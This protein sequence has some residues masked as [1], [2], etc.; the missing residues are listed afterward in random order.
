MIALRGVHAG[1]GRLPVLRGIS[2][3]AVPGRVTGV[4]GPNGTGK[5]TLL[6]CLAR[7]LPPSRGSAHVR[8]AAGREHDLYAGLG[9]REAARLVALV[10]QEASSALPLTVP[11][12]VPDAEKPGV[13]SRGDGRKGLGGD[14]RVGVL[15]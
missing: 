13:G 14:Y 2:M 9:E 7:L 10:P 11:H 4:L 12:V 1:Y 15:S 8:D 6:R 5:S 3:E